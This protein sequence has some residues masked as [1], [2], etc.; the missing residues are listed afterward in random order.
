MEKDI[1]RRVKSCGTA[2]SHP[3]LLPGIFAELERRR[4]IDIVEDA[5]DSIEENIFELDFQP[6]IREL[7]KRTDT[8]SRNKEKRSQWLNTTYLRNGLVSWRIQ[9]E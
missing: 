9:L 6:G 4:H 8:A 5:V 3:L 2:A 7:A 1:L